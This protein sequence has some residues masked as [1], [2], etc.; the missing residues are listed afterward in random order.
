MGRTAIYKKAIKENT[1]KDMKKLGVFKREYIPVISVYSELIE[2]YN[3]LTKR[4]LDSE[5]GRA[6]V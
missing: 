6:H 1:I 2:Q 5:I 4:F 3:I